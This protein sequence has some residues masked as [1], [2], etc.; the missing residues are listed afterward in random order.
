VSAIVNA[1]GGSPDGAVILLHD[2]GGNRANT[3]EAVTRLL[4]AFAGRR[5]VVALPTANP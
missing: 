2:G 1:V 4:P 5:P 3:V